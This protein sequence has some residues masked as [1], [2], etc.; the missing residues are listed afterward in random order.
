MIVRWHT[1]R[2]RVVDYAVTL[3]TLDTGRHTT[4]RVYDGAHG[5]NELHRYTRSGG[6]QPGTVFHTGT[7]SEGLVA[8]Q[9]EIKRGWAEMIEGWRR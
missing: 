4:V 3:T 2:G 8:A 1:E 5:I 9:L 7:L 6:K